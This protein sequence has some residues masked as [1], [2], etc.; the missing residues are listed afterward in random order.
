MRLLFLFF[1]CSLLG[2]LNARAQDASK[3]DYYVVIGVFSGLVDA[4]KLT[5]EAN[6][7]GFSAQYAYHGKKNQYYVYLFQTTDQK[8]AKSFLDRIRKETAYKNASIYKG[9]LSSNHR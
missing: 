5:D 8:K 1:V 6:L 2:N 9:N 3:K 7:K 4:E